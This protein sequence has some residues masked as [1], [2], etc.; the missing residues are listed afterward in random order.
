MLFIHLRED[1]LQSGF[2]AELHDGTALES[3][4]FLRIACDSGLVSVKTDN[5]G[6]PLDLGRKQRTP[7]PSL[8][9]ALRLRHRHCAFPGCSCDAFME[10]HHLR[11]CA[12][13]GTTSLE[14]TTLLC[15]AHHRAVHEGGFRIER[16]AGGQLCFFEPGGKRIE[17]APPAAPVEHD[18]LA[19]LATEQARADIEIARHTSLP[20]Y[21]GNRLNLHGAVGALLYRMSIN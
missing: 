21:N 17:Q 18:V 3:E 16:A 15:S 1:Q 7:S 8:M 9:R 14:N 6:D 19:A 5:N 2:R 4:T 11:H 12:Q 20:H 13:G 10:A